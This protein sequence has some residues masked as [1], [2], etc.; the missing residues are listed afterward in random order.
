M[1]RILTVVVPLVALALSAGGAAADAKKG[2]KID[3]G[4]E[5]QKH[6][7]VCHPGGG[8]I[9]NAKKALHK[10][11]LEANGVKSVKDI[12]HTMRHPGPGMT[13][14][15]TK[16]ISDKEAKAIAAYIMKEFK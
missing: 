14:F 4:K 1:K 2:E 9:V 3:G 11:D 15:D 16:T 13:K 5:F 8:N 10:K 12:I 6:C 7:A